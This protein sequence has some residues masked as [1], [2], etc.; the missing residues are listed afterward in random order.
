MT[1]QF[2]T[3]RDRAEYLSSQVAMTSRDHDGFRVGAQPHHRAAE[4][5]ADDRL[6]GQI[7]RIPG[8]PAPSLCAKS[9][10]VSSPTASPNSA[11]ARP[12][13]QVLVRARQDRDGERVITKV[14]AGIR[15]RL[16]ERNDFSSRIYFACVPLNGVSA[17]I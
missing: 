16:G 17:L 13:R 1:K 8:V 9:G 5:Q 3:L 2:L 15:F 12:T 14:V 4:G 11:G 6:L 10:T 7:A